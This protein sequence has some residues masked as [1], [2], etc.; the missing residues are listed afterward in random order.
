MC[1]PTVDNELDL[2]T[3]Q[4]SRFSQATWL[5]CLHSR[6]CHFNNLWDIILLHL[7]AWLLGQRKGNINFR[8]TA[9][10]IDSYCLSTLLSIWVTHKSSFVTSLPRYLRYFVNLFQSK[11]H[12][13]D[14]DMLDVSRWINVR[15]HLSLQ[16][17]LSSKHIFN[18]VVRV[19]LVDPR[20][21]LVYKGAGAKE[22]IR[23]T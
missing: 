16:F 3:V 8:T 13:K 10:I 1:L 12:V 5:L 2:L 20:W 19:H 14:I 7:P 11:H 22:C 23:H 18:N 17:P 4:G 9:T 21:D 6:S 15:W